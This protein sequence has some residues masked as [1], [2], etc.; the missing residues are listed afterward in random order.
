MDYNELKSKLKQNAT[1]ED[2]T[3]Y[4]IKIKDLT[5]ENVL[6]FHSTNGEFI[7]LNLLKSIDVEKNQALKQL[8]RLLVKE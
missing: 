1:I 3:P 2:N 4:I 5:P 8:R 6:V 7:P